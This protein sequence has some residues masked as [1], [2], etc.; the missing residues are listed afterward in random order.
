VQ[1]AALGLC[2][3][4][5]AVFTCALLLFGRSLAAAFTGEPQVI[6]LAVDLYRIGAGCFWFLP[7]YVIGQGSL[8]GIGD[9]RAGAFITVVAAWGCAPLF[10]A[11]LGLGLGMG[12]PGGW[13]GIAAEFL[14]AGGCF[15]WRLRRNN[16]WLRQARRIRS[17][18]R[19]PASRPVA[20][21]T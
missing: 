18:L 11:V 20:A 7:L 5:A 4:I 13:F 21:Q 10:A 15:W 3:A 12:A 16:A 14:L 2:Y 17:S 1:R 6:A 8:R 19:L 9:V